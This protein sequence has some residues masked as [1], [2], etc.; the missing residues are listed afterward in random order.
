MMHKYYFHFVGKADDVAIDEEGSEFPHDAAAMQYAMETA[1]GLAAE[2]VSD[3]D[4][5][6]G[7]RIE[8]MEGLRRVGFVDLR[9]AVKMNGS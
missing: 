3:G 9:D 1:R 6:A 4:T 8:V 2:F 7:Q 5:I